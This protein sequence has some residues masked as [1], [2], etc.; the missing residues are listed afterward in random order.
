VA[1]WY[2]LRTAPGCLSPVPTSEMDA[3]FQ[4]RG[5]LPAKGEAVEYIR[6]QVAELQRTAMS[7][8][9]VCCQRVPVL[10]D[11]RLDEALWLLAAG[12]EHVEA[13]KGKP[14]RE[15]GGVVVDAR[16]RFEARRQRALSKWQPTEADAKALCA[17][18]NQRA[19]WEML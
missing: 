12:A 14:R 19:G 15:P 1:F 16:H 8:E 11:G 10:P 17:L 18:V 9:D 13:A 6:V 4:G 2:F 5:K 3:F 7:V